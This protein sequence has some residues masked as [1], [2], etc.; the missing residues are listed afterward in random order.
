MI[1]CGSFS[2]AEVMLHITEQKSYLN[3]LIKMDI[4]QLKYFEKA[5]GD[6]NKLYAD[7]RLESKPLSISQIE[8]IEKAIYKTDSKKL[9]SVLRELLFLSGGFCPFFS[10]G[11]QP[12][13]KDTLDID[14]LLDDQNYNPFFDYIEENEDS[15]NCFENRIIW[16]FN[17]LYESSYQFNFVY[18]DEGIDN[19]IVY[20]FDGDS[21]YENDITDFSSLIESTEEH[22][23]NF[24]YQL[25]VREMKYKN[26]PIYDESI[27]T[28][29]IHSESTSSKSK[30]LQN[31]YSFISNRNLSGTSF[32][33][34]QGIDVTS[35]E[36]Q[37]IL[38][39]AKASDLKAIDLLV[40]HGADLYTQ[41][42]KVILV[43]A[44]FGDPDFIQDLVAKYEFSQL[45]KNKAVVL[46]CSSGI[47][48]ST[49]YL[50]D[51]GAEINAFN[52]MGLQMALRNNHFYFVEE[53]VNSLGANKQVNSGFLL[54]FKEKIEQEVKYKYGV[55]ML[56]ENVEMTLSRNEII[57]KHNYDLR[58]FCENCS[59]IP[60]EFLVELNKQENTTL[61]KS[62]GGES[63]KTKDSTN[64]KSRSW[65][66][67]LWS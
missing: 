27:F 36:N 17:T 7:E 62:N 13:N 8:V 21:L 40:K 5:L 9:P 14:D 63:A 48:T 42:E 35:N 11:I 58:H 22:L 59:V 67:R 24:I 52:S 31:F 61:Y 29:Y 41:N 46:T 20:S 3:K 39:A 19:P 23:S 26:R 28:T 55:N 25:Y 56:F 33:I 32:F 65:W 54:L 53:L 30:N 2:H 57:D 15:I 50:I 6:Y 4:K 60:D 38:E 16:S 12:S 44:Q 64:N 10:T 51:A 47:R 37:A 43:A 45:N 66:K 34:E 1:V 49:L 18:L